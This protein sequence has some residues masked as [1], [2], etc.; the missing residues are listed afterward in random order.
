MRHTS[1][2][3]LARKGHGVEAR[4]TL[5]HHAIKRHTLAGAHHDVLAHS[6][7]VGGHGQLLAPS[8]HMG[9]I[10][11]DVHHLGNGVAT[12]VFG[13][14]LKELA[15]LEKQHDKHRLG[16]LHLGT[17]Q[18]TDEQR[19]DGGYGHKEILIEGVALANALPSLGQH[20]VTNEQ[21]R[22]E[23]D[24]QL[25]PHGHGHATGKQPRAQQQRGRHDYS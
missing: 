4:R 21:I 24:D 5:D 10:G 9:R 25:L 11:P 15:H 22:Y 16:K 13:V 7:G 23:V 19:T 1:G 8:P 3:A 12:L 2:H 20:I 18:E 14:M 6:H 17:R